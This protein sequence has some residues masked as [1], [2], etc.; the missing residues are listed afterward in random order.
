MLIAK[1]ED[2]VDKK[3]H[4][5]RTFAIFSHK[6]LSFLKMVV[7]SAADKFEGAGRKMFRKT[8]GSSKT[9]IRK[10]QRGPAIRCKLANLGSV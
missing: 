5:G 7:P 10:V 9:R 4:E 2:L 8:G 6:V 3:R 1:M